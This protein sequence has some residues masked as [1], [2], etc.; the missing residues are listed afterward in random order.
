[1]VDTY[2]RIYYANCATIIDI[3]DLLTDFEYYIYDIRGSV[4]LLM[5]KNPSEDLLIICS[6][7]GFVIEIVN[8]FVYDIAYSIAQ[9]IKNDED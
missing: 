7:K 3:E 6:L 1:M 2:Y 8:E 5:I 4:E 9:H